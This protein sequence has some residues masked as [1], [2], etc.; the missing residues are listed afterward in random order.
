MCAAASGAARDL[1]PESGRSLLPTDPASAASQVLAAGS[2]AALRTASSSERSL[3]PARTLALLAARSF[4][5]PEPLAVPVH[6]TPL[7]T[8]L[9]YPT[10]LASTARFLR[11][12]SGG[13]F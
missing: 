11:S 6:I 12:I 5:L 2:P 9:R 13:L 10:K 1:P 3:A 8:S 7:C 4:L